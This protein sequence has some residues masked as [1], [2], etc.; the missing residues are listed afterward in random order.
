MAD[1]TAI[2]VRANQH[3]HALRLFEEGKYQEAARILADALKIRETSEIWNDWAT[4]QLMLG[5]TADSE[6]G[7]RRALD[8]DPQSSRAAGNLGVQLATAGR[9][10]EAIALLERA[11]SGSAGA[12]R[13]QLLR[14]IQTYRAQNTPAADTKSSSETGLLLQMATVIRQQSDAI[15]GLAERVAALESRDVRPPLASPQAVP[16]VQQ[17]I[18]G[19]A[20]QP[21]VSNSVRMAPHRDGATGEAD[22]AVA[23]KRGN[24]SSAAEAPRPG[25]Y[26]GGVV[27]GGSGYAEEG[28]VAALGLAQHEIPVHLIPIGERSDRAKIIPENS[29]QKLES[30]ERQVVDVP[31]SV[32]FHGG[33]APGWNLEWAGRV[34]VGRTMCETDGL[35]DSYRDACNAMDEV[36]VPSRFNLETFTKGGVEKQKLRLVPGGVDTRAFSP[37]VAPL[38]I[39]PRRS[40]NFLSVFD[41]HRRKGYDLLLRAYLREFT[42]DDD[43]ALILKVYQS[44][45]WS[46]LEAQISYFVERTAG[47]PMEK[48]PAIILL[49]GFIPQSE[50]ARLYATVNAFVLPSRGE[51]YGRPYLEAMACQLPVIATNW[52]GQLDFLNDQNSYLIESRLT[53]VPPDV[54][55]EYYKGHR[56]AEP[57]VDHLRQLMREVYSHRDEAGM[58]AARGREDILRNYD[59]TVVIPR[60]VREFQRLLEQ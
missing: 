30:L 10:P 12:E 14:L 36:W 51:G 20:A 52:S 49:N 26:F 9:L 3:D 4:A 59:W 44:A 46:N 2:P 41:W 27:Y 8:L 1:I 34:R 50:M 31:R 33:P 47:L 53:L 35:P 17:A 39:R 24:R 40:F 29:R 56:W 11:A 19:T 58:K 57:S 13:E 22:P 5:E 6:E 38:E 25:V 28:W 37:G 21:T 16:A 48:A 55:I 54:E 45:D 60:W 7:Y 18:S 23:V 43:V 32:I 15:A 42:P